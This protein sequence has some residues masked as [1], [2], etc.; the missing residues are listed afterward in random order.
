MPETPEFGQVV[1]NGKGDIGTTC[2]YIC[3]EEYE[4]YGADKMICQEYDDRAIWS[5]EAPI[6]KPIR[7]FTFIVT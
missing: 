7:K 5:N 6:C 2:E 1:C 3:D 4:M